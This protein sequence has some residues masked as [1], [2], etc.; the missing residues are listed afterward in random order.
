MTKKRKNYIL[1]IAG[2]FAMLFIGS[3]V[4]SCISADTAYRVGYDI[5]SSLWGYEGETFNI[6][7][8]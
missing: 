1:L 6:N 7:N 2:I 5:G 3:L 8:K 4:V